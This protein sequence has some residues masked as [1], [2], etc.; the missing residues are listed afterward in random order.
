MRTRPLKATVPA[1]KFPQRGVVS[2]HAEPNSSYSVMSE[3][4]TDHCFCC[5]GGP[6]TQFLGKA[7]TQ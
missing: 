3:A 1:I 5:S 2:L 4:P 6:Y 7:D